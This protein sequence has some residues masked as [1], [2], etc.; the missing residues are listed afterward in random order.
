MYKVNSVYKRV[1]ITLK[2]VKL[3]R[4]FYRLPLQCTVFSGRINILG[5]KGGGARLFTGGKVLK[6]SSVL[7]TLQQNACFFLVSLK[8]SRATKARV[9]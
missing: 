5:G 7:T 4:S 2:E 8:F 6:M 9:R 1:T 3:G